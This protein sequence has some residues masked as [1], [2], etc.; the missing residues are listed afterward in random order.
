MPPFGAPLP[1]PLS[2][3]SGVQGGYMD[4]EQEAAASQV[5]TRAELMLMA[6]ARAATNSEDP[7]TAIQWSA[8]ATLCHAEDR[9]LCALLTGSPEEVLRMLRDYVTSCCVAEEVRKVAWLVSALLLDEGVQGG[10]EGGGLRAWC[11]AQ[12]LRGSGRKVVQEVVLPCV[13]ADSGVASQALVTDI[14]FAMQQQQQ[15]GAEDG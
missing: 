4:M 1:A 9:L 12:R 3:S 11:A 15:Y 7:L 10:G 2:T 14:I 8:C 6:R 5:F 13:A